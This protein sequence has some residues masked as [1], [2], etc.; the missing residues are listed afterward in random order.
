MSSAGADWRRWRRIHEPVERWSASQPEAGALVDFDGTSVNWADFKTAIDAAEQRLITAG[1]RLG[2]RVMIVAENCT[3]AVAALYACSRLDAWAVMINA[4]LALPEIERIR[5][6]CQP[7]VILFT[8]AASPD[9]ARHA[10]AM[11]AKAPLRQSFG[12]WRMV[13]HCDSAPEPVAVD[14]AQVAAVIYTSGTTGEPKG[15][16]LTH[17]GMLF[18]A[19]ISGGVRHL[20]AADRVYGVLPIS[21]VFGLSSNCNGTLAAG[22]ALHCVPRFEPAALAA[23]LRDGITVVQGVPAMFAKLLEYLDSRGEPLVAP[24]LRYMSSGG[25]PLDL[26][27]KRRVESRFGIPL[28]NGYGL[29]EASP[30]I[31][32]T[33]LSDPRADDSVGLLLPEL[34]LR[35]V[36]GEGRAVPE[37]DVGEIL[38]AGPNI[39]KGYYRNPDATEAV[40]TPDGFLRTG[41]LGRIGPDGN[42]YIAGRAKELIIRSGFNVYPAEIETVLNAHAD[43]VQCAVIGRPVQGDEEIIA[44]VELTAASQADEA[45]LKEFAGHKLAAYKRPQHIIIVAQMPAAP[46]GKIQRHALLPLALAHLG[47]AR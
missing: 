37:G 38:V 7:R 44:F 36:D 15:V 21:H 6:H 29:T 3:A 4:R 23:A 11:G 28:N 47:K 12:I 39:M 13:S 24:G 43:V 32:Q 1:A 35:I 2:D 34:T 33:V 19:F 22:G 31:A 42:L 25:A 17:L 20:N 30:T 14:N 40:L 46:T 8:T 10:E 26:D 16:M 9:A 45:M 27:W 18:V 5:A 41:D